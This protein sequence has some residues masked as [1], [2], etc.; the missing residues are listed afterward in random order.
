M[1][2]CATSGSRIQ[3]YISCRFSV[4]NSSPGLF[5]RN[6]RIFSAS[7]SSGLRMCMCIP[8]QFAGLDRFQDHLVLET[9]LISGSSCIGQLYPV[10]HITA[11][12]IIEVDQD[13]L[14]SRDRTA[15]LDRT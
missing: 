7:H 12:V 6:P 13:V 8:P 9:D 1:F 14:G 15:V 10:Y 5:S 3:P 2:S 11:R 4:A